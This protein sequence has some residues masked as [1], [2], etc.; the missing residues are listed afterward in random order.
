MKTSRKTLLAASVLAVCGLGFSGAAAAAPANARGAA[1]N[2]IVAP[3]GQGGTY[4][5]FL[6][7]PHG[8]L[9]YTL[10]IGGGPGGITGTVILQPSGLAKARIEIPAATP[11]GAWR[12]RLTV[13]AAN[14]HTASSTAWLLV[15][16]I[17]VATEGRSPGVHAYDP[18]G[19][20]VPMPGAFAGLV[21][22]RALAYRATDNTI[23]V[24]DGG[25][26][27]ATDGA[28]RIFSNA[29]TAAISGGFAGIFNPTAMSYA[30]GQFVV[31]QNISP[32]WWILDD[33]YQPIARSGNASPTFAQFTGDSVGGICVAG[34]QGRIYVA[35]GSGAPS[36]VRTYDLEGNRLD[37]PGAFPDT[38]GTNT[39][40]ETPMEAP[41]GMGWSTTRQRLYV[42]FT[43]VYAH[44]GTT[45]RLVIRAYRPGGQPIRL[46]GAFRGLGGTPSSH[47]LSHTAN[48]LAVSSVTGDVYAITG[49]H[50]VA[51]YSPDGRRLGRFA[52]PGAASA[53]LAVP[54]G[55]LQRPSR[56]PQGPSA[57]SAASGAPACAGGPCVQGPAPRAAAENVVKSVGHAVDSATNEI[58]KASGFLESLSNLSGLTHNLP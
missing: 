10:A 23:Y 17:L 9:P 51:I 12:L 4:T 29:G 47:Y 39:H 7:A 33:A 22:P 44:G 42:M 25:H 24:A 1:N 2:D 13:T 49:H 58:N 41:H 40:L 46:P 3:V 6:P 5:L 15:D 57:A 21:R 20:P 11:I 48:Q 32:R 8:P 27:N 43:N 19:R 34:S 16:G 53:I 30:D 31:R 38:G 52:I 36:G 18:S 50:S 14:D 28:I 35:W 37:L 45:S 26:P 56:M 54:Y 55:W